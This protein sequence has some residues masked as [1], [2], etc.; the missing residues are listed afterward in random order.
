MPGTKATVKF[1]FSSEKELGVGL[2]G[3][4]EY[5]EIFAGDGT[6]CLVVDSAAGR[7]VVNGIDENEFLMTEVFK[8]PA[9]EDLI[10]LYRFRGDFAVVDQVPEELYY[11]LI[12]ICTEVVRGETLLFEPEGEDPELGAVGEECLMADPGGGFVEV[13]GDPEADGVIRGAAAAIDLA[14]GFVFEL[15]VIY[16]RGAV[17]EG[18]PAGFKL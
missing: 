5:L 10:I 18:G 6:S 13:P 14:D 7:D 9:K 2:H 1:E 8:E 17:G 16:R 12:I 15:I 4:L 11:Y 3:F